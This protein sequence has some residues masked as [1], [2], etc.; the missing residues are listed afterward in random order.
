MR[1]W[2]STQMADYGWPLER[3]RTA[4]AAS[5]VQ[6]IFRLAQGPAPRPEGG[7]AALL[8]YLVA[9]HSRGLDLR[10]LLG[11][12]DDG[13]VSSSRIGVSRLPEGQSAFHATD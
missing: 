9:L 5:F 11:G 4:V 8:R 7:V 1:L 12:S 2:C 10:E 13:I 6:V 3:G